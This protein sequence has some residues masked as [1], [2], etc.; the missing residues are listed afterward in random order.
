MNKA[1]LSTALLK[2][3]GYPKR[4]GEWGDKEEQEMSYHYHLTP[5][6]LTPMPPMVYG[7]MFYVLCSM[8]PY[9]LKNAKEDNA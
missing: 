2:Y 4:G 7:P 6:P 3:W 8:L 1:T 5:M 9:V